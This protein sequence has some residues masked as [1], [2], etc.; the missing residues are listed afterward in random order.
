MNFATDVFSDIA[1]ASW[2]RWKSMSAVVPTGEIR[3]KKWT[4]SRDYGC[5]ACL[6][7]S[8]ASS[9]SSLRN[10]ASMLH[11]QSLT[12]SSPPRKL[13]FPLSHGRGRIGRKQ[14]LM[15]MLCREDWVSIWAK[16]IVFCALFHG[17]KRVQKT[18][19]IRH[20]CQEY[21]SYVTLK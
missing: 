21:K 9:Q 5:L 18:F 2:E 16:E 8:G 12:W 13:A 3:P 6:S 19:S 10:N 4:L 20:I 11:S 17:W 15:W 7:L 1:I 14:P